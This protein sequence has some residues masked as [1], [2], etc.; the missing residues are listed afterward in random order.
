[1]FTVGKQARCVVEVLVRW[2]IVLFFFHSL[3]CISESAQLF[4]F[5]ACVDF[6]CERCVYIDLV[7]LALGFKTHILANGRKPGRGRPVGFYTKNTEK[8]NMLLNHRV[9]PL[10]L[11]DMTDASLH[12]KVKKLHLRIP[13]GLRY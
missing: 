2:V 5:V 13:D 9:A 12:C 8:L 1:M 3:T 4:L 6:L 10:C 7:L 11:V